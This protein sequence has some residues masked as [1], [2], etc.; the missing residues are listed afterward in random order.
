MLKSQDKPQVSPLK[1]SIQVFAALLNVVSVFL[2]ALSLLELAA[3]WIQYLGYGMF[4]LSIPLLLATSAVEMLTLV[5]R[6]LVGG[7]FIISGFVKANDPLGFSYKL[8]EYFSPGALDWPSFQPFVVELSILICVSE[9]VLGLAVILG[10]K[11]KLASWS[12]LIMIL[13]FVWLT[14]YTASCIDRED[15][16]SMHQL[17]QACEAGED[18]EVAS[19]RIEEEGNNREKAECVRDCGCFGD[20]MKGSVGRSLTPWES[21]AKDI[22]LLYFVLLLL[23]RQHKIKFNSVRE[24]WI[25]IPGSL[26]VVAFLC[27]VFDNWYFPFVF[28]A[29]FLFIS[30]FVK[31]MNL[32]KMNPQWMIALLAAI[33]STGFAMYTYTYLPVKDYRAYHVGANIPESMVYPENAEKS[34]VEMTFYYCVD[35]EV[36]GYTDISKIPA[37]ATFVGRKDRIVKQGYIPPVEDFQI[38]AQWAQLSEEQRKSESIAAW[39]TEQGLV[40]IMITLQNI[41]SGEEV[42]VYDWELTSDDKFKDMSQWKELKRET[43]AEEVPETEELEITTDILQLEYVLLLISCDLEKYSDGNQETINA[44]AEEAASA[45]IPFYF[46]CPADAE[47]RAAFVE[48]LGGNYPAYQ[49]DNI[50]LKAMIRSNPGL[51]LLNRGI[52]LQKWSTRTIPQFE[53]IKNDYIQ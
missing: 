30:I 41:E 4:L 28:S 42:T 13:F 49:C 32:G 35:G 40:S 36:Q 12:L 25:L 7:L 10:V 38:K 3:G 43:V 17:A 46:I 37:G 51:F 29:L 18:M 26:L 27:W 53:D 45:G 20:A 39:L 9:I 5:S 22:V 52:V 6:M 19:K 50:T 15:N 34:E 21:F 33:S 31:R 8:E 23:I 2:I 47:V 14:Y 44:L 1:V 11:M 16:W 48:K 24:D